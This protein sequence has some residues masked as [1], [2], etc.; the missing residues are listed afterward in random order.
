MKTDKKIA[1]VI[2]SVWSPVHDRKETASFELAMANAVWRA[3][4]LAKSNESGNISV[5]ITADYFNKNRSYLVKTQI[6]ARINPR[7]IRKVENTVQ[8]LIRKDV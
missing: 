8:Q 3:G 6:V 2:Y 5:V 1:E 7:A 4:N